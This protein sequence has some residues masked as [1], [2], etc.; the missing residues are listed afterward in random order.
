MNTA[1]SQA[2]T[3]RRRRTSEGY[4]IPIN[5]ALS[6]AQQIESGNGVGHHPHRRHCL[7]RRRGPARTRTTVGRRHLVGR[8]GSAADAAGLVA[9][10]EI[11]AIGGQAI[12]SPDD[13]GTIVSSEK[14]GDSIYA[15]YVAQ[16]GLDSDRERHAGER[17][18]AVGQR[19]GRPRSARAAGP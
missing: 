5:K 4:A 18:A 19:T 12:S 1:A 8:S 17:A 6:I 15:T 7:P 13:L 14:S 10:D 16:D 11:V 3:S 2:T 9:G